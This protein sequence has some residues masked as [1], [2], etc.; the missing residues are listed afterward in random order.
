MGRSQR[1]YGVVGELRYSVGV[2]GLKGDFV[3][4]GKLRVYW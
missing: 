2:W 3:G 4:V 1:G